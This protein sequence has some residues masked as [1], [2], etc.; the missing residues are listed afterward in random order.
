MAPAGDDAPFLRSILAAYGEDGPRLLYADYLEESPDPA[1]QARAEFI[2]LQIALGAI[3]EDHPRRRELTTRQNNLLVNHH[4][5]WTAHLHGLAA[6]FQFRRGLLD[7]VSVDAGT[8]L[9]KGEELFRRAPI[10]RV[11]LN[12]AVRHLGKLIHSPHLGRIRELDLCG[13]DL[14]NGGLGLLL[15][16][17]HLQ[18][19]DD[20]DVSHNG[21]DAAAL[22][23]LAEAGTIPR[24]RVLGLSGNPKVGEA[25]AKALEAARELTTLRRFDT[26]GNDLDGAAL[27]TLL[28]GDPL[29]QLH[30]L[31]LHGNHLGDPGLV[32]LADSPLL[33]RML[34]RVPRLDLRYNR[35]GPHG[36]AALVRS[37]RVMP[38]VSLDLS[39][40]ALGDGGVHALTL[41][42]CLPRLKRLSLGQNRVGDW[43]AVMLA[44]SELMK[45]L[46]FLDVSQNALTQNGV[47]ALF[48]GRKHFDVTVEYSGNFANVAGSR[49]GYA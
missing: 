47:D 18:Y 1:D 14:G 13:N 31:T 15:R 49:A 12:D 5:A 26:S 32:T 22:R 9:A 11:K 6:G 17:Q 41:S 21:L 36:V 46:T 7:T 43:G 34:A 4:S 8:F 24:L 44:R 38:V 28:E 39:G 37:T 30:T 20:L 29:K 25:G 16:S 23:I 2:R 19:L 35:I 42:S 48:A 40:N 45:Q 33:N 27:A 3:S 10:R